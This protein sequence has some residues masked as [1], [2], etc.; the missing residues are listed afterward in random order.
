[1]SAA[2][3]KSHHQEKRLTVDAYGAID[4]HQGH[5]I[6]FSP[7]FSNGDDNGSAAIIGHDIF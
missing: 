2:L 6:R 4:L 1:M 3:T 5:N 7:N